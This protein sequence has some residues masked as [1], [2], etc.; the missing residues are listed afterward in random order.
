MPMAELQLDEIYRKV[1]RMVLDDYQL[2]DKSLREWICEVKAFRK[3]QAE[4]KLVERAKLEAA[5]A[6]VEQLKKLL[7]SYGISPM[8]TA[9]PVTSIWRNPLSPEQAAAVLRNATTTGAMR[10]A[11]LL[12]AQALSRKREGQHRFFMTDEEISTSWRRAASHK[13]QVQVL[14]E[15]NCVSTP[16]MRKKLVEM[17]LLQPRK[18]KNA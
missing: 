7:A 14:A 10:I 15:L 5:L 13:K 17:G 11:C 2:D 18:E 1:G 9:D 3:K 6:E 12:G 4:N 8:A 16:T